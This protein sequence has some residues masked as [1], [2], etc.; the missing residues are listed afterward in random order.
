M[1]NIVKPALLAAAEQSYLQD[2]LTLPSL[3]KTENI[4]VFEG[5][6]SDTINVKVKGLLPGRTYGWRNDRSAELVFDNYVEQSYPVAFGG[7]AYSASRITQEEQTMDLEGW[8]PLL[9]AEAEAV[10]RVINRAGVNAVT[11]GDYNAVVGLGGGAL[12]AGDLRRAVSAARTVLGQFKQEAVRPILVVG[13]QFEHA[14]LNDA[15]ITLASSV[16]DESASL[17]VRQAQIGRL[18][19]FDIIAD[20]TVPSGEAF[21]I[22]PESFIYVNGAPA[23]LQ[24]VPWG[25]SAVEGNV[26]LTVMA[27]AHLQSLRD[28][29]VSVSYYGFRRY[30]EYL[31]AGTDP[32][33]TVSANRHFLGGVKLSLAADNSFGVASGANAT[34]ITAGT[35]VTL[36]SINALNPAGTP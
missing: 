30:E 9:Q 3:F 35:G 12:A 22:D 25:A 21:A 27:Q 32:T 20:Y 2:A 24:G 26:S 13:A 19:G 1:T 6:S 8:G 36:A 31:L 15:N 17:A 28:Q 33:A 4:G 16:G 29:L 7:I 14:L 23:V 18:L 5:S 10:A 34:Q 11:A